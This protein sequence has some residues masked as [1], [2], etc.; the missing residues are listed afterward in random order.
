M[1]EFS[2][3][4]NEQDIRITE[5]AQAKIGDLVRDTNGDA[6]AV[7]VYVVGGGCSGMQYGMSFADHNET[8]DSVFEAPESIKLVIDPIAKSFLQGAEIDYV[9]DGLS[10]S[11][12]FNDVFQAVGGS[13]SCGGCGGGG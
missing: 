12:V 7:R 3:E 10:A 4:I 9:D 1:N 2:C 6:S 11:F 8:H 13:G 5:T